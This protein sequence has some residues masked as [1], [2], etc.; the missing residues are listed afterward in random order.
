MLQIVPSLP[1]TV[2]GV[3]DYATLL[4]RSLRERHGVWSRFVVG[5]PAWMP[6]AGGPEFPAEAVP[7]R[8]RADLLRLLPPADDPT[9]VLVH[10]VPYG[11]APR[12]C[13][14]WLVDALRHLRQAQ[15]IRQVLTV[16]HEFSADNEPPWKSAF[17]LAPV[18]R[19][20]GR[21]L[22]VL[23]SVRRMT[24]TGVADQLRA[25]L[26]PHDNAVAAVPVFSNLGEPAS[27]LPP[28]SRARR[29]VVFGTR[30]WREET[31]SQHRESLL[32]ACRR[33]EI[34]SVL[35]VGAPLPSPPTDLP[36]PFA[37]HGLLRPEE[38]G[39]VFGNSLAGFFTYPAP[40]LGK[41]GIFAAYV[42]HGMVPVTVPGNDQ[43]NRDGLQAGI[44]YLPSGEG[45]S[46][47]E[48]A[49]AAHAWYRQHDLAAHADG[50]HR[51]LAAGARV[52]PLP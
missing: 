46:L 51:A 18:Q 35:D 4:A 47:E 3:G 11:Y 39:E 33:L 6:P 41:S 10:Y 34:E 48:V 25:L 26:P 36:V 44:H 7:A 20:L 42:G 15:P 50:I 13:P 32:A 14:F 9:P 1:P 28:G 19:H 23:S 38:A 30:T 8:Q 45:K 37:A 22:G 16:F 29:L 2:S 24:T 31:Y 43:P 49:R 5:D 40:W 17:W 12:G 21:R 52:A 27:P